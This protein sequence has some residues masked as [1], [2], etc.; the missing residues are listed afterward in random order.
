[1]KKY[2]V[3]C[4][5]IVGVVLFSAFRPNK[6]KMILNSDRSK[7]NAPIYLEY[8]GPGFLQND[9][10]SYT[11]Y[12]LHSPSCAGANYL[13]FIVV[14]DVDFS[15]DIDTYEFW[16]IFDALDSDNDNDLNDEVEK[17]V[18]GGRLEKKLLQ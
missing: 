7:M 8:K 16:D 10:G 15:G 14:E 3:K 17:N 18:I 4:L 9:V 2:A 13:C 12:Q 5:V 11:Q 1:M 6:T